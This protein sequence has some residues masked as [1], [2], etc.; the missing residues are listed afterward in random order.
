MS[1]SRLHAALRRVVQDLTAQR[2]SFALVGGLAVSARTEPRF[3]RDLDLAVAVVD[4]AEAESLVRSLRSVGYRTLALVEQ[5]AVGRLATVRL[6]PP[7]EP[8]GGVVVDLLFASSGIEPEIVQ[9]A[10]R[11]EI[12]DGLSLAVATT[13]YLIATKVLSLDDDSR[14]QDRADLVALIKEAGSNDLACAR[15]ALAS[16]R[17]RG[18]HRGRDLVTLFERIRERS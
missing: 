5:E 9:G 10:E 3:T 8:E 16:I 18:Y 14:P 12:L 11:L 15:N 13:G 4:D 7:G 1:E 17:T 6:I 2:A